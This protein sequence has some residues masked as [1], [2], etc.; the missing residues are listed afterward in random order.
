MSAG[1]L[2]G[3]SATSPRQSATFCFLVDQALGE[4]HLPL[5]ESRLVVFSESRSDNDSGIFAS[6]PT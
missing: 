5:C 4:G 6:K 3:E 2:Y 1:L